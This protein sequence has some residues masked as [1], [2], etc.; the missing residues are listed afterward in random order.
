MFSTYFLCNKIIFLTEDSPTFRV[1][2]DDPVG[3]DVLNH[4]RGDFTWSIRNNFNMCSHK[5]LQ[6]INKYLWF[7]TS[8]STLWHLPAVLCGNIDCVGNNTLDILQIDCGDA[9]DNL[10]LYFDMHLNRKSYS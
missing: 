4:S 9:N 3:S 2:K 8:K 10:Q 7:L 1:T 5:Y 6:G